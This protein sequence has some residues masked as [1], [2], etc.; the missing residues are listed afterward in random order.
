MSS[1]A[2][3]GPRHRVRA[4]V[5]A[6]SAIAAFA[7]ARPSQ[8]QPSP[9][10]RTTEYSAYE[11]ES[12][13]E[14]LEA[15]GTRPEPNPEGKIV[16]DI[17]IVSLDIIEKRDPAPRF[18]NVFHFTTR[19]H[20]VRRELLLSPGEPFSQVLCDETA[21]NLRQLH[22]LSLVA[23]VAERGSRPDRVR[24]LVV[25]K[26]I[27][28]LRLNSEFQLAAGKIEYLSLQ[29]SEENL[30][31]TH[32]SAAMQFAMQPLSYEFGGRYLVRRLFGSR[33][34]LSTEA[35][36]IMNRTS[37]SAE[38]SYGTVSLSKPLY[39]TRTPWSWSF[40]VSWRNEVTRRYSNAELYL[41]RNTIPYE[42]DSRLLSAMPSFTRSFGWALKN[43]ITAGVEA[44][45]RVFDAGDLSAY[46]PVIAQAF[47]QRA[48]PTSDTR[49]GPFVQWRTYRTDYL[50]VLEFETLGLQEDFR[51]GHDLFVRAWPT[52]SVFGSSRNVFGV[53]AGAQYTWGLSDGLARLGVESTNDED[54]DRG[55][56]SDGLVRA[57]TRLVTPRLGFGRIVFDT[58]MLHRYRNHLNRTSYLGGEGRLRGYPTR[59]FLGKDVLSY[60]LEFRTAALEVLT[61]QLGA[62]AFYD[63]GDAFDGFE[64]LRIKQA[65]GFGLRALFPQLDK[66]VLRV[67]VGF[68]LTPG[69]APSHGFPGQIVASFGQA[70]PV[71][72]IS[73]R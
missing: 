6:L 16:E 58:T 7:L 31:G 27:W 54:I 15:T 69:Y 36:L 55:E 39:S 18:L 43:D 2:G 63:V 52:P 17:D 73:P 24:V 72:A 20:V 11:K 3:T 65:A 67:D 1:H 38:G 29:P 53:T 62:T 21:R 28:S 25:T 26:D 68:P 66:L 12:V 60:N 48:L 56:L 13:R 22:Q 32:H 61:L 8:A 57:S 4:I 30:F 44:T 23:C 37:G 14:A 19:P 70:F 59:Y 64:D 49:V 34:A 46:D 71:P 5:Q 9:E 35:G 10:S 41:Y 51:L 40:P 47:V 50:R 45:R 33:V 42:Y